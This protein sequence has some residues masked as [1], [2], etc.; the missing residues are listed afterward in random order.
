MVPSIPRIGN[1]H[2]IRWKLGFNNK[3]SIMKYKVC[4]SVF[5]F[6]FAALVMSGRPSRRLFNG[7]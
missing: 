2:V 6:F 7:G 5:S 4:I 1:A 3:E